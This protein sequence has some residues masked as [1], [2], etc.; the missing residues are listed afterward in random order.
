M[1][2]N[3]ANQPQPVKPTTQPSGFDLQ[4]AYEALIEAYLQR[5]F[6]HKHSS[7][8][9]RRNNDYERKI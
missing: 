8:V 6:Q 1:T 4:L 2:A 5:L 3:I 9:N 7:D